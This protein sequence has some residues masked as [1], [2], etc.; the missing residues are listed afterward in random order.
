MN[1]QYAD[2]I[3]IDDSTADGRVA[4]LARLRLHIQEV[5]QQMVPSTTGAEMSLSVAE[6]ES[7][8]RG[9]KQDEARLAAD[10]RGD[11]VSPVTYARR[12]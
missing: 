11:A 5:S 1:W 7:Y 10:V 4:R 3:T 9:L 8:L 12:W 6:L 2:W